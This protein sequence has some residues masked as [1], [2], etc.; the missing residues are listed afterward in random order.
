MM[1]IVAS[2]CTFVNNKTTSNDVSGWLDVI[3]CGLMKLTKSLVF[4]TVYNNFHSFIKFTYETESDKKLSF[5]DR[6]L[7]RTRDNIE[8][9]VFR[10]TTNRDI[11]IHWNSFAPFQWKSST[12]NTLV[13][14]LAGY[15]MMGVLT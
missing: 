4:W 14:Q 3:F 13:Y 1:S 11:Y 6:Q 8:T 9:C 15:Y 10:K 12:L 2:I 7:I 5:L